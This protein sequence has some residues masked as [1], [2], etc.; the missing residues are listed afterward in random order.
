LLGVS[1]VSDAADIRQDVYIKLFETNLQDRFPNSAS[2]RSYIGRATRNA[3]IDYHNQKRREHA[4]IDWVGTAEQVAFRM[5]KETFQDW[6]NTEEN[7]LPRLLGA[8]EFLST[9]EPAPTVKMQDVI[10]MIYDGVEIERIAKTYNVAER[11][12]YRWIEKFRNDLDVYLK[13]GN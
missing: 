11:T 12:V 4:L 8:V 6:R 7:L 2:L 9:Y 13:M 3:V 5:D 10:D 1:S